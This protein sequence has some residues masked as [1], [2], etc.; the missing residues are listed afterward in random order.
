MQNISLRK[1]LALHR[2]STAI[3]RTHSTM[4]NSPLAVSLQ[5]VLEARERIRE[6][7]H[8]TPV[9]EC[10]YLN[11]LSGRQLFFKCEQFQ[12]TGS[13]KVALRLL[14]YNLGSSIYVLNFQLPACLA[15]F[16]GFPCSVLSLE[17]LEEQRKKKGS[18]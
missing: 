4:A 2:F 1:I 11:S 14:A 18:N 6:R 16:A 12:K 3:A 17:E 5:D 15:S 8:C 7:V 13:F 10:T 9:L